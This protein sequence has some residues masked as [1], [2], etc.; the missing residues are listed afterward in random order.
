MLAVSTR[1]QSRRERGRHRRHRRLA[2]GDLVLDQVLK[3]SLP[4]NSLGKGKSLPVPSKRCMNLVS[5]LD[6]TK[7]LEQQKPSAI[8]HRHQIWNGCNT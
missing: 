5:E 7:E 2:H 4:L 8:S 1:T 6:H 3:L